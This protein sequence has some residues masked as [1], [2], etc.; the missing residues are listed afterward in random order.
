[1]IT[2]AR[3]VNFGISKASLTTVGYRL[4]NP[5]GSVRVAR[6]TS[7]I[8]E[9]IAGK[10]I[11]GGEISFDDG[12]SGFLVWDTGEATPLFATDQYD[13]RHFLSFAPIY[14][15]P[16]SGTSNKKELD[17]ITTLTRQV[18]QKIDSLPEKI[19]AVAESLGNVLESFRIING[20]STDSIIGAI[21]INSPRVH[22]IKND[23]RLMK[24]GIE[25]IGSGIESLM[26]SSEIAQQIK[27]IG[28]VEIPSG[29]S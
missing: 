16:V 20:T 23:I 7:G 8:S 19:N 28:N 9:V 24:E 21:K 3:A 12:W 13:Y 26:E 15:G 2:V 18:I 14:G 5:D 1:M 29:K 6:T 10:G 11:Y 22:E 17:K 27:E 4:I 25:Q